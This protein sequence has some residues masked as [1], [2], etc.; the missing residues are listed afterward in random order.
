MGRPQRVCPFFSLAIFDYFSN[1]KNQK[2]AF[3]IPNPLSECDVVPLRG[4][5][6]VG[7]RWVPLKNP[8]AHPSVC[9]AYVSAADPPPHGFPSLCRFRI[10]ASLYPEPL[11]NKRVIKEK[12]NK[13]SNHQ[14]INQKSNSALLYLQVSVRI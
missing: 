3:P 14:S 1:T 12:A 10:G 2:K 4:S 13:K 5:Q 6:A 9:S 11:E 8:F 7:V